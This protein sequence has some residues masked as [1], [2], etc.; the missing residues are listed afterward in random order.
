MFNFET[1]AASAKAGDLQNW[2][3]AYA[4][5]GYWPTWVYATCSC[6]PKALLDKASVDRALAAAP[7]LRS[8]LYAASLVRRAIR[9]LS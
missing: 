3:L 5:T 9:W 7:V 4:A 6:S 8:A 1:C 2:V